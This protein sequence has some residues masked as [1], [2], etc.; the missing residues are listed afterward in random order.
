MMSVVWACFAVVFLSLYTANLAAFMIP[1]EEYHDLSGIDDAR[2][3][4]DAP[5]VPE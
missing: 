4:E 3:R 1:R 2:V 5:P